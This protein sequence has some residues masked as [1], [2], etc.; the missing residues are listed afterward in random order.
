M[1]NGKKNAP[2]DSN[3]EITRGMLRAGEQRLL[4]LSR[5]VGYGSLSNI[6]V[7]DGELDFTTTRTRRKF[8]LGKP[9]TGRHSQP[10]ADDF[11]L[12]LQHCDLIEK[13]RRIRNGLIVSIDVQDGLPVDLVVEEDA[14]V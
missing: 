5:Q 3:V 4:E 12:K 10:V 2:I 8:R 7:N 14:A 9:E 6:R 13:L 1:H 11:K